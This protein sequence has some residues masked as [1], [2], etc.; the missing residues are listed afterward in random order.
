MGAS[1]SFQEGAHSGF[2][3]ILPVVQ[4][5]FMS[6]E[7]PGMDEIADYY[8]CEVLFEQPQNY[9]LTRIVVQ[10]IFFPLGNKFLSS[11]LNERLENFLMSKAKHNLATIGMRDRL[12]KILEDIG[13]Q[14]MGRE[15]MASYLNVSS[16]T[17]SRY[18]KQEGTTWRN[19][20]TTL[21]MEKARNAL[22]DSNHSIEI[23]AESVGFASASAFSTA[24]SRE[25][26]QSPCEFRQTNRQACLQY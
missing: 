25:H 23:V 10:N 16:R 1:I 8:S 24:F 22:T 3:K 12:K 15:Q 14:D 19:L 4:V 18:L 13:Y 7:L 2:M 17:L 20:Y 9:L 5:G 21:R 6:K 11:M 26:G